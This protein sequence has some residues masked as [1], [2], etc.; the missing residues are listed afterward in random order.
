[1]T[2]TSTMM[3]R[4]A[5]TAL[6]SWNTPLLAL[7][8]LLCPRPTAW[9]FVALRLPC[10]VLSVPAEMLPLPARGLPLPLFTELPRE[11]V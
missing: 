9:P 5:T 11:T 1:M 10:I 6:P 3:I 2:N 8:L 7:C 4:A